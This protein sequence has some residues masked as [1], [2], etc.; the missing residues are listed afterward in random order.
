MK[1]PKVTLDDLVEFGLQQLFG[2]DNG[3]NPDAVLHRD[4]LR[5]ALDSQL[6]ADFYDRAAWLAMAE[7]AW[8]EAND[9][10]RSD[11]K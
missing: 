5:T 10:K 11:N 8:T 1:A 4:E 6:K 3:S 7:R 2:T 9:A